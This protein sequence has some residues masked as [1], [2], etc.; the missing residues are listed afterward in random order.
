MWGVV[1]HVVDVGDEV[2]QLDQPRLG[3][4]PG[5]GAHHGGLALRAARLHVVR[6]LQHDARHARAE[7]RPQ[8][9]RGGVGVLHHVVQHG[10]H[11]QLR[12]GPE[13]GG[14]E[15]LGHGDGMVDVGRGR[16]ALAAVVAVLLRGEAHGVQQIGDQGGALAHGRSSS[17][18]AGRTA[19][20]WATR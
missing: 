19:S 16:A 13:A 6:H 1:D 10:G 2:A 4:A 7:Q 20:G 12:V 5:D 9:F 18:G 15:L 11:Q 14:G 17:A 3:G 8:L